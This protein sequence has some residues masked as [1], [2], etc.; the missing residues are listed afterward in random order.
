MAFSIAG[1]MAFKEAMKKCDP[2]IMEPIMKVDVIVPDEYMGNVIGDLNSRR[3]QIQNQESQDGTARVTAEVPLSE[4]FGYAT[5]LRSKTQAVASIPW[6]CRVSAGPEERCGQD[7]V[8][9]RQELS[10]VL[11]KITQ[12]CGKSSAIVLDFSRRI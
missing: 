10:Q 1:S 8:R 6:T 9:A 2:V 12:F 5:D 4:M 3:G 7:H 11:K